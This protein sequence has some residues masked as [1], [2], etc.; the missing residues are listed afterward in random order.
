M[1]TEPGIVVVGGGECGARAVFELRA[2][3]WTGPV[4]LVGAEDA[5]PYERPPLSKSVM[6]GAAQPTPLY[7]AAALRDADI[8]FIAGTAAID[9][10]RER[11]ELVLADGRRIPYER[12]LLATG[13]IPRRLPLHTGALDGVHYLRSQADALALRERLRPGARIGIIGGGFIGLE[14][15]ASAT[16][17]GCAVTV[18]EAAGR[19]MGR[20][21][22][23]ELAAI[24]AARHDQAG[25][26]VR[27]ET[28]VAQL[29]SRGQAVLIEHTTGDALE[30]DAVV[31]GIGAVPETTLAEKAGLA[32]DNG[33]QVDD[34]LRTSDPDIFAAGDCCSFPHSLYDN[35][36]I[37]LE[38]WRNAHDQGAAAARNLLG[39]DQPYAAVPWF[40]SDQYE[41]SL[42][43][44]GLPDAATSEVLRQRR[45]G[46]EI[47]F[48]LGSDGRLLSAAAV[49]PGNTAAKDIRLAEMLIAA[50]SAPDPTALADPA[51]DLKALLRAAKS[52]NGA[53][54]PRK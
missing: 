26:D 2:A 38:A 22:P 41:L 53:Q 31:V 30:C 17:R 1:N 49:G 36:R 10:D 20:A 28:S 9:I 5:L 54:E 12:M 27:C 4:T 43:V 14:L 44:T 6:T 39:A 24:L 13:A 7:D 45:D 33:I 8:G 37:R 19:L 46:V 11:R 34:R 18:I 42:H 35:R 32:V 21:V 40:W 47:R 48:G 29:E 52:T 3:G 16:E 50:R 23:A 15:A 25:V 51:T